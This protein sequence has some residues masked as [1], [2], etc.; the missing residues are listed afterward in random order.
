MATLGAGV[1]A[2]AQGLGFALD[3][4]V[5]FILL[6]L[7]RFLRV[8]SSSAVRSRS[9]ALLPAL[10]AGVRSES[11]KALAAIL[12]ASLRLR[13]ATSPDFCLKVC[14]RS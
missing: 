7:P 12:V 13:N 10:C 4:A 11:R 5:A 14:A 1:V 2:G 3:P 9:M 8:V 6:F